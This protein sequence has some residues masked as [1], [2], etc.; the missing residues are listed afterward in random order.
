MKNLIYIFIAA[1]AFGLGW[2]SHSSKKIKADKADT[3]IKTRTTTEYKRD[4][5]FIP[6]PLPYITRFTGDSIKVGSQFVP[7]EQK[8]YT[9]DST[10][11][12][13]I[14]GVCP[15]IDS[16]TVYPKTVYITNDVYHTLTKYKKQKRFGIGVS[17]GYG[18]GKRGLSPMV[19]IGIF[20][21]I[22]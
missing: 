10:Y 20:Y 17:A 14:S 19:G 16:V 5:L 6:Y 9:D 18:I 2:Y 11:T 12:V 21:R 1:L 3:I 4:T 7:K 13:W 15:N 22:W 8:A